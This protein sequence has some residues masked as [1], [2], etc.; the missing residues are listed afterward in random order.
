MIS[1]P[2]EFLVTNASTSISQPRGITINNKIITITPL[3]CEF[4][5]WNNLVVRVIMLL[6]HHKLS[7]YQGVW[8]SNIWKRNGFHVGNWYFYHL[9][10]ILALSNYY[11]NCWSCI[12]CDC[13][14]T[15]VHIEILRNK[16]QILLTCVIIGFQGPF[17]N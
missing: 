14:S 16:W 2:E 12:L 13:S 8:F 17:S 10:D 4:K 5:L 1:I 9:I 3:F 6:W 15:A 11:L 7:L